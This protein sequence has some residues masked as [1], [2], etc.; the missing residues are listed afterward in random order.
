MPP[1][2]TLIL[3]FIIWAII[4]VLSDRARNRMPVPQPREEEVPAYRLPPEL[5]EKW[6][7]KTEQAKE[8]SQPAELI[9]GEPP[10]KPQKYKIATIKDKAEPVIKAAP[11]GK[12]GKKAAPPGETAVCNMDDQPIGPMTPAMLRNGIVLSEILGPPVA[13]RRRNRAYH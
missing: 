12:Q 9:L 2:K 7:P 8:K 6:G 13:R 5:R 11:A 1:V 3:I 10:E 4:K